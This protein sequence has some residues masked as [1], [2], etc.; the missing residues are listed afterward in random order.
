MTN[1]ICPLCTDY[2][3]TKHLLTNNR[4]NLL[5]MDLDNRSWLYCRYCAKWYHTYCIFPIDYPQKEILIL[6]KRYKQRTN[7]HWT[8]PH[9]L[10]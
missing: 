4:N 6:I 10:F 2:V 7:Q 9:H 3:Y 5:H 8:C 1:V